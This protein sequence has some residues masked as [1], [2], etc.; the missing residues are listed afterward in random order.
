MW[1]HDK[2]FSGMRRW[3]SC[4][5]AV[6]R[7][8]LP[9][10]GHTQSMTHHD[11]ELPK[12]TEQQA[13]GPLVSSPV[14]GKDLCVQRKSR[15]GSPGKSLVTA[16]ITIPDGQATNCSRDIRGWL[17]HC[18][19]PPIRQRMAQRCQDGGPSSAKDENPRRKPPLC[20]VC[21]PRYIRGGMSSCRKR[22]LNHRRS[23]DP[24]IIEHQTDWLIKWS[25]EN[26]RIAP[27]NPPTDLSLNSIVVR[28]PRL[29]IP[30]MKNT[31]LLDVGLKNSNQDKSPLCP[32]LSV[33]ATRDPHT[34]LRRTALCLSW[35]QTPDNYL[36]SIPFEQL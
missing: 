35:F 15:E 29:G 9:Q 27:C 26:P 28:N 13:L 11:K 32:V 36:D 33:R 4:H 5:K 21:S 6:L 18:S 2:N 23:K 16:D 14:Q 1:L 3:N 12:P 22:G 8:P 7:S 30:Y 17:H 25:T 10:Q 31:M 34:D 24:S 20:T 19:A